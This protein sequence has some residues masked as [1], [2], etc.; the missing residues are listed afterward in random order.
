MN[1]TLSSHEI[2]INPDL[3]RKLR[4][5]SHDHGQ[6]AIGASPSAWLKSA[7]AHDPE[8]VAIADRLP[9]T[10]LDRYEVLSEVQGKTRPVEELAP[11]IFSWGGMDRRRGQLALAS[12]C[13]WK[14]IVEALV[15]GQASATEAYARFAKFRANGGRG[16][17]PAYFTKLIF[18]FTAHDE[19][20]CGFIMDQWTALSA[21][22]LTGSA[23][24]HLSKVRS[25]KRTSYWVNDKNTER[26]YANFCRFIR[27]L[28]L[29]LGVK[30][31]S[32]AEEMVYS[33]GRG[34][35]AWREILRRQLSSMPT[36]F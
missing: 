10:K 6:G 30:S 8:W 26:D 36:G 33:E 29:E 5:C 1:S 23:L 22:F 32:L 9:A 20:N 24:V 25:K 2:R 27:I 18:F 7:C 3:L 15:D 4:D 11:I 17:G 31:P 21:N 12:F 34:K 16:M 13:K 35:G 28:A 19:V 14:E